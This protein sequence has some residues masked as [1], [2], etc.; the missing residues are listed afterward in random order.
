[1]PKA[2]DFM[3]DLA[4]VSLFQSANA[5]VDQ[6]VEPAACGKPECARPALTFNHGGRFAVRHNPK[7]TIQGN[8]DDIKVASA[9]NE[10]VDEGTG[11]IPAPLGST[12][13]A[14]TPPAPGIG[15]IAEDI[16]VSI[17]FGGVSKHRF[18]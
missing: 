18:C 1:M 10:A 17:S 16:R 13:S 12:R 15:G 2:F 9:W 7:G 8:I 4:S 5:G 6:A 14:I 3:P 11:G